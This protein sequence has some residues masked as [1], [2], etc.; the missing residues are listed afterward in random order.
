MELRLRI[1]EWDM[2]EVSTRCLSDKS[3]QYVQVQ[4]RLVSTYFMRLV[5]LAL[6]GRV[7]IRAPTRRAFVIAIDSASLE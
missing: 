2:C 6:A 3:V 5:A 1:D 4:D 7:L